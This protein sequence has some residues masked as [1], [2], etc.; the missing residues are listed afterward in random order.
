MKPSEEIPKHKRTGLQD[1]SIF[2]QWR[3]I[4]HGKALFELSNVEINIYPDRYS[5]SDKEHLS[6]S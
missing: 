4:Y 1:L 2:D 3:Y 5:V 6:V